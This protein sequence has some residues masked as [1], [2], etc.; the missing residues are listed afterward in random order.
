MMDCPIR[1]TIVGAGNVA[2]GLAPAL[3]KG[4]MVKICRVIARSKESAQALASTIGSNVEA[5]CNPYGA[6][7]D[8]DLVIVAASDDAIAPIASACPGSG[9]V[10]IHTSGSVDASVLAS[11]SENYGVVYPMQTFTR[12]VPVDL[13]GAPLFIEASSPALLETLREIALSVSSNVREADSNARRRLHCAAVFACNFT[14][15]LWSI[16]DGIAREAGATIDDFMP[17]IDETLRKAKSIGPYAGQTGPARRG[18]DGVMKAHE[19][20]LTPLT[21]EIYR[22]LSTSIANAYEQD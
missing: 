10:W 3:E 5:S 22:L 1:A 7:K 6:D 4:G 17:L 9:A 16:A 21:R 11:A 2:W 13:S 18:A 14:N 15:H 19:A 8:V 20:M 12:G